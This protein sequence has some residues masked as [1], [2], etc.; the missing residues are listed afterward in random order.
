MRSCASKCIVP[1][2]LTRTVLPSGN[3]GASSASLL[4]AGQDVMSA[5]QNALRP[6]MRVHLQRAV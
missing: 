5:L 2:L 4:A 1:P 3:L 6:S